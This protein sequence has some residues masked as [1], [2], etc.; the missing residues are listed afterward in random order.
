[1][2]KKDKMNQNNYDNPNRSYP[3]SLS[4]SH[5]R[6]WR[7]KG[8]DYAGKCIDEYNV[9][10]TLKKTIPGQEPSF[11][12]PPAQNSNSRK[13]KSDSASRYHH[14]YDASTLK[15]LMEV[16]VQAMTSL[17][18]VAAI[19]S[20]IFLYGETLLKRIIKR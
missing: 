5:T 16:L 4:R 14:Y 7:W 17:E 10:I 19:H 2:L 20:T 18:L 1:M 8:E 12:F 3:N 6:C 13:R 9:F 15:S 11:A